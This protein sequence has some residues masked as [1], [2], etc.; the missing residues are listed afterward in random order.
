[1]EIHDALTSCLNGGAILFCGSGFSADCLSF[2]NIKLGTSHPLL[3]LF[4]HELGYNFDDLQI[5]ADDY[6][7]NYGNHG[8]MKL[9][10]DK[11][12]IRDV[13]QSTVDI[14]GYPWDRIYTTNYDDSIGIALQR[15]E[16]PFRR[17]SNLEDPE[18]LEGS[19][20]VQVI[21]LH[22]AVLNWDDRNFEESCVLGAQSYLQYDRANRWRNQLE[23]DYNYCRCFVFVGYSAKDYHLNRVFF[24]ATA[25]REKVFFVNAK[26]SQADRQLMVAQKKFGFPLPI[27]SDRLAEVIK[28]V[29]AQRKPLSPRLASFE[30]V[31]HFSSEI[32]APSIDD[33][34]EH[35]V[36][37][38]LQKGYFVRDIDRGASDY[39]VKRR[40]V[41]ELLQH[42]SSPG[43]IGLITGSVCTGKTSFAFE[44]M[45]RLR[46]DRRVFQLRLAY[47]NIT[48][49]S[50][51]LIKAY[52]E[53]VICIEECFMLGDALIEIAN[54]IDGSQSN[55]LLTSRD[56]AYD[57]A[58][59]DLIVAA[60]S[61]PDRVKRFQLSK[62]SNE[63]IDGFVALSERVAIW[64][65]VSGKSESW[66]QRYIQHTCHANMAEFLLRLL[67]SKV[68]KQ[69]LETE[70]FQ[71]IAEQPRL[72]RPLIVSLYLQHMGLP[73]QLEIVSTILEIDVGA[74]LNEKE[75]SPRYEIVRRDGA[76]IRTLPSISAREILRSVVDD[77]DIVDV[78]TDV[79]RSLSENRR[80]GQTYTHIFNQFMRYPLLQGVV[81]R[82]SEIDRFFDQLSMHPWIR[83]QSH[84]WLQFSMA[85]TDFGEYASAEKYL[86]NAYGIAMEHRK[87]DSEQGFKQIDDQKAKFLLK[88]RTQSDKFSDYIGV[89]RESSRI[90]RSILHMDDLTFH[91]YDTLVTYCD[92][93]RKRFPHDFDEIQ[94][95]V[96]RSTTRALAAHASRRANDLTE[97]HAR[98]KAERATDRL[99]DIKEFL[100]RG[101][102][103][104]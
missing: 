54:A 3:A 5:A 86:D 47:S 39:R 80:Y 31:K 33:V 69:K 77:K 6:V 19:E 7:A 35:L 15:I 50:R 38:T 81:N 8:L 101:G 49:E 43:N 99:D 102:R 103:Q 10:K 4:N 9:L 93:I 60:S 83:R 24:N 37:G 98:N 104:K 46:R 53:C 32:S 41:D 100:E 95:D 34:T 17:V 1:M 44:I 16:K 75:G 65:E 22:G 11:Y 59:D 91:V 87:R 25:S 56:V 29:L 62:L 67:K 71:S 21:H 90:I 92:F 55:L 13:P 52:P 45:Q 18:T 72:R 20:G 28:Q 94:H 85:K 64:G 48:T 14:L 58:A 82:K 97:Y 40:I 51:N 89:L 57:S 61:R 66:K 74:L 78:V 68:V 96:V 36:L 12:R 2:G 63:E 42:L 70:Y 88:S 30:E 73:A 84:F 26:G 76:Y 79:V 27:G 23:N